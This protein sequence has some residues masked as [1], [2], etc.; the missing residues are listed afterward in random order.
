VRTASV[1]DRWFLDRRR[2][3]DRNLDADSESFRSADPIL[4]SDA[5]EPQP[6][7][8]HDRRSARVGAGMN[9]ESGYLAAGIRLFSAIESL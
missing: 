5:S 7:R 4:A 8:V 9:R 2:G 1:S 3:A 6:W